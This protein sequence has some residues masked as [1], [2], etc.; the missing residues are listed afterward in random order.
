MTTPE[1]KLNLALERTLNLSNQIIESNKEA[2]TYV[3][4]TIGSL[5][6]KVDAIIDHTA[7]ELGKSQT[8]IDELTCHLSQPALKELI[9][10]SIADAHP[11]QPDRS[12]IY[13]ALAA[14]QVEINNAITKTDNDFTKKKYADLAS[15]LDA[16]RPHLSANGIAL[17]QITEDVSPSMLGIRTV[18][19]HGESGQTIQDIITMSPPKMDPQGIGS[20]RTYM[21]RYAILA[22]TGIAGASDD[23]AEGTKDDPNDYPRIS[24]AEAE[25]I[26][27]TADE[28]F[29]DRAD[30]AMKKMLF[31]VFSG[32]TVVG[33]I[34]EGE[35]EVALEALKNSKGLMDKKDAEVAKAEKAAAKAAKEEK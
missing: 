9:A 27:Y 25:K 11:P 30:A 26:I 32:L 18:L 16:V 10:M 31:A 2:R 1:S 35:H 24:T 34:R 4:R 29:G 22:L 5:N 12:A 3:D 19:A 6:K 28:L 17:F 7:T 21:R 14:A 8:Q 23:D 13:T 20:C 15:V 33:D